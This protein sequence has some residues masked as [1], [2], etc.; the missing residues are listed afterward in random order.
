MQVIL[1]INSPDGVDSSLNK[2][3]L[4]QVIHADSNV[5]DYLTIIVADELVNIKKIP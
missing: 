4:I 2:L 1:T 5:G 3:L